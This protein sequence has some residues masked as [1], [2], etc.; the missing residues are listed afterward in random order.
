[1][2]AFLLAAGLGTRLRPLTDRVPKCL[3]PVGG[4]PMLA[5]WLTLL[6]RHGFSDV[7]VNVHHLPEQVRAFCAGLTSGP[8]VTLFE[9]PQLL[10]SGGTVRAN[11]EWV[12]D[13]RPFLIAYA[14]NLTDA[15]LGA[16]VATHTRQSALL[17][18]A[19][20][21]APEPRRCGIAE[22]EGGGREGRIVSFEEKPDRPRSN[23][24]N[25]GIYLTDV[26]IVDLI[27]KRRPADFGYDV[28]PG[29]TGRMY[30][31]TTDARFIDVG[32]PESYARAQREVLH[33][34]K[35][36]A[37]LSSEAAK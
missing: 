34:G 37:M 32:T 13:G 20:F 22:I 30:G 8:R 12:D 3:V 23:L 18:M 36:P 6:E 21:R 5:H 27:P 9:E 35:P 26:R 16:L 28:L 33:L 19:L 17:T 24:A 15:D 2:K 4:R 1:M 29:L 7:L 14:D 10:G 11:R 31:W 25:A